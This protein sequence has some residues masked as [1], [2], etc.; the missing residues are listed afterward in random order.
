M[1]FLVLAATGIAL[2]SATAIPSAGNI[3]DSSKHLD[4][5]FLYPSS[6]EIYGCLKTLNGFYPNVS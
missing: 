1:R 2:A 5:R 4:K 3:A 6:A